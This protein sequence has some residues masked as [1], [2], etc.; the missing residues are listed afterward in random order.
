L[1]DPDDPAVAVIRTHIAWNLRN[2]RWGFFDPRHAQ[3]FT[4]TVAE[5]REAVTV[6]RRHGVRGED[7]ARA[8][9]VLAWCI[10]DQ[11]V[12]SEKYRKDL[13][14]VAEKTFREGL[15]V[16]E[17][18]AGG[19]PT[20]LVAAAYCGLAIN[21]WFL[22]RPDEA[23]SLARRSV[24][25]HKTLAPDNHPFLA[26]SRMTLGIC[27]VL[28]SDHASAEPEL[29]AALGIYRHAH[30]NDP[31]P[32]TVWALRCL[33]SELDN[34]FKEAEAEAVLADCLT[35]W[36]KP[37][38]SFP[39]A[40]ELLYMRALACLN[41]GDY[42]DAERHY[43]H[44]L[45]VSLRDPGPASGRNRAASVFGIAA[46]LYLQGHHEQARALIRPV[47]PA[48]RD[49]LANPDTPTSVWADYACAVSIGWPD[50]AQELDGAAGLPQTLMATYNNKQG[51]SR[52]FITA[53]GAVLHQKRGER[54]R[55]LALLRE[56]NARVSR[57][58]RFESRVIVSFLVDRL[59][60]DENRAEAEAVLRDALRRTKD[61]WPKGHPEIA[62]GQV[63]LAGMLV[64]W[65]QYDEAVPLLLDAYQSLSDHPQARSGSLHRR[66]AGVA[67]QLAEL[68]AAWGKAGEAAAW[69]AKV[70]PEP[71]PPPRPGRK[72]DS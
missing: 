33:V 20:L 39:G 2:E 45:D 24:D 13:L 19:Q 68:Y 30:G 41:R 25:L 70:P 49:A 50:T 32:M 59:L 55:A 1:S 58:Q 51:F 64:K 5:A 35:A 62:D 15:G 7:L 48:L 29:R 8:L 43:R 57:A 34:Q 54:D 42:A 56:A 14:D 6:L 16:A 31:H 71:A 60:E 38:Y 10:L 22:D 26:Q 52:P 12:Y 36:G 40:F 65:E 46:T 47:I 28:N 53:I 44:A 69:R 9:I 67:K 66:R 21:V 3:R 27:H 17:E 37:D 11:E 61:V 72:S 4:T 63:R 18:A 23:L